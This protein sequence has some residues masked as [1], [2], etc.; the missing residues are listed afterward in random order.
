MVGVQFRRLGCVMRGVMRMSTR[1]VRVMSGCLVIASRI[2]LGGFA[3]M[4]RR[5]LVVL[6]CFGVMLCCFL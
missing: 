1:Q 4:C 6:G 3:M 5:M 2:V